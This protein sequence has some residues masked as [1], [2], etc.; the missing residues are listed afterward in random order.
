M[1]DNRYSEQSGD[2]SDIDIEARG[3]EQSHE[4]SGTEGADTGPQTVVEN[5][6]RA[7]GDDFPVVDP[8]VCVGDGYRIEGEDQA[9]VKAARD[10]QQHQGASCGQDDQF[11]RH[12]GKQGQ[13]GQHLKAVETVGEEANRP[14]QHEPAED[15]ETHEPGTMAMGRPLCWAKTGARL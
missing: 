10:K 8:V 2:Q 13:N 1:D 15:G 14:L 6:G 5:Q 11:G 3:S 12:T 7:G 4:D 9:A